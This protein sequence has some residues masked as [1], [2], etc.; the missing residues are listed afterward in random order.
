MKTSKKTNKEQ[1]AEEYLEKSIQVF[2][3]LTQ[4]NESYKVGK[5][6]TNLLVEALNKLDVEN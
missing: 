1:V 3:E 2:Y 4:R 5:R 6:L